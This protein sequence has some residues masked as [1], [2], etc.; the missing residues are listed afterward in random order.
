M[1]R[2]QT[3]FT[4]LTHHKIRLR[5]N[6]HFSEHLATSDCVDKSDTLIFRGSFGTC[7]EWATTGWF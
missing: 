4:E 3:K 5:K 2:K 6:C 1:I 7:V